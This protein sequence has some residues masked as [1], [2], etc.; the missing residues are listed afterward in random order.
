MRSHSHY[1]IL[2]THKDGVRFNTS[3][4]DGLNEEYLS[5]KREYSTTQASLVNDVLHI[6]VGYTEPMLTL[7]HILSQLDVMVSFGHASTI[8]PIPYVRPIITPRGKLKT[9]LHIPNFHYTKYM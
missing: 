9:L 8:A 7:N 6:V 2:E 3:V 4:V 1:R 5:L